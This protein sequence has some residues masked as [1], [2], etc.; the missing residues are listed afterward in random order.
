M[1]FTVYGEP[2][3]KGRPKFSTRDGYVRAITPEKT[4]SYENLVR[5]SYQQQCGE[6]PYD[7]DIQLRAHIYAYFPIPKSASKKKQKDMQ[8][9]ILRPM[10]K[11]DLDNIAKA[12]LDALNGIAFYD[13]SQIVQLQVDKFYSDI[14]RV[15]V[16][17]DTTFRRE[18]DE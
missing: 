7:K 9:M 5:L 12:I 15:D 3:A 1:D 10:K 14:P 8:A 2:V 11:P 17:I 16:F 6:K 4:V 18:N 13:D